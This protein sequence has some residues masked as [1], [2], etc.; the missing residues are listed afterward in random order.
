[1]TAHNLPHYSVP[2][3]GR[4]AELIEISTRLSDPHCRLLN[5]VG[6]GGIG[7][8]R[9]A[10]EYAAQHTGQFLD[11]TYFVPFQPLASSSFMV[12]TIADVIGLHFSPGRDTKQQLLRY[13]SNLEILLLL[14]NLEHLLDGV[15][16]ISAILQ[17][18]PRVSILATS[19][20]RLSL[21]EEWVLDVRGLNYPARGSEPNIDSYDAVNLFL[22]HVRRMNA[23]ADLNSL[24][25]SA[26]ARICQLVGGM[27]L[28]IELAAAWTRTLSFAGIAQGIES[29]LDI[30][31]TSTRGIE[32][33]HRTIRATIDPMWERLSDT[34]RKVAEALSV[35]RGGFTWEAAD[36]V[37]GASIHTLSSLVDRS[38]LRLDNKGRYDFHELLRQYAEERLHESSEDLH[39]ARKRHCHYFTAYLGSIERSLAGKRQKITLGEI[40]REIDNIRAAWTW[41][42]QQKWEPAID[43]ACHALWFFYDTRS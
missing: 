32:S 17:A 40:H 38:F 12:P 39:A 21:S 5:L 7:K 11:G 14:D 25:R 35:F 18:A 26:I 34:Q 19:R 29:S 31:E 22:S 24:Q 1:M 10:T 33:R 20:E 27:P 6:P 4:S 15:D 23:P 36:S 2:F 42:V 3:V 13:L 9:L 30:L 28:G 16:L 43:Q 8:T 37:T 41:A